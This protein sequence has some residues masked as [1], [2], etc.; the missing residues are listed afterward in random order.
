MIDPYRMV[1]VNLT[2]V[3]ILGC[4]LVFYRYVYPKKPLNLFIVLVVISILPVISILRTGTYESGDLTLHSVFLMS[5]YNS[6]K[7]GILFPQ[8]SGGL[9]G[10]YGCPVFIFEYNLPFYIASVFHFFGF[11]PIDSIKLLLIFSYISSGITMYLW[12]KSEFGNVPGFVAAVLYLFAPYH[13]LDMHFR[14][15]VGEVL[16]FAPIPLLFLFSKKLVV[17]GKSIYF[18]LLAISTALLI[19]SHTSTFQAMYPIVMIYT[20]FIFW[21]QK[22]RLVTRLVLFFL[23]TSIGLFLTSYFW[24]PALSEVMYTWYSEN[25]PTGGY[26]PIVEYLYSPTMFG[27]LF[28]GNDGEHRLIIGYPHLAMI[29]F[30]MFL[31]WKRRIKSKYRPFLLSFIVLFFLLTFMMTQ[32]SDALWKTVPFINNFALAW[33]LLVPITFIT[34]T[35]AALVVLTIKNKPFIVTLCVIT[36]F[37]T[38]L[39][40]GN[41]KMVPIDPN[42]FSTHWSL[43]T[44]YYEKGNPFYEKIY[45]QKSH[46]APTFVLDRP[47]EPLEVLEGDATLRQIERSSLSHEYVA[48][49]KKHAVLQENTL[50]FPGW[51]VH[52]NGTLVA[53]NYEHPSKLGVI[54]F[55]LP[56]GLYKLVVSF[57][58]TKARHTGKSITYATS[59]VL[60]VIVV[61]ML[62]TSFCLDFFH[63][64]R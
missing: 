21:R 46:L 42:S 6:L 40:W 27:F 64:R 62:A 3:F 19:L 10:G 38:I 23:S 53:I 60:G 63:K 17:T 15:S 7:D 37:S 4:A 8:W 5:F 16:S 13:L 22:E 45:Q 39:N 51:T 31:L 32:Y 36:I 11:T 54:T 56:E 28:Q 47:K 2:L 58:D 20:L 30:G 59:F 41:R 29:F 57:E 34:S 48:H 49:I 33:R 1:F 14:V 26:K 25:I 24:F 61:Y 43:Y 35:V 12:G 44:E 52:A 50:Y 18:L 55:N 9:C